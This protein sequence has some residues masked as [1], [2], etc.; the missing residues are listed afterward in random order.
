MVGFTGVH[1]PSAPGSVDIQ[2]KKRTRICLCKMACYIFYLEFC[3]G[4][5]RL[6]PLF[7]KAM[8]LNAALAMAYVLVG[9]FRELLSFKCTH[10]LA[11]L[12]TYSIVD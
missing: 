7:S 3:T 9:S 5:L 4:E 6:I 1:V 8:L 12:C 11:R 10:F 2:V